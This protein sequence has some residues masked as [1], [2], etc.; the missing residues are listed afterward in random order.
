MVIHIRVNGLMIKQMDLAFTFITMEQY[1][2]VIGLIIFKMVQVLN[3]GLMVVDMKGNI[4]KEK[5]TVKGYIYG[6]MG[7]II[8]VIGIKIKSMVMDNTFGA[9]TEDIMVNGDQIR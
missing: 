3:F 6:E 1:I 5:N 4:N 2:K 7:V 8:K 9:I